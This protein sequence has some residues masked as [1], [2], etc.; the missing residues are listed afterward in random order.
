MIRYPSTATIAKIYD[1]IGPWQDTQAFYEDPALEVLL[2]HGEFDRA[3]SIYE[4]GSGTGRVAR[5]ILR[6]VAERGCRY[7]GAD[8]SPRMV[9]LAQAR[10]APWPNAS[11]VRADITAFSPGAD[12]DRVLSLFVVDLLPDIAIAEFLKRAHE[13]LADD[14]LLCIAGLAEG[15][16]GVSRM[17]SG[18]WK[19]VH[20]RAPAAVGGCRPGQIT[21][22]LDADRWRVLHRESTCAYG[23][24]S[25][26][27]VASKR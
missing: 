12:F 2:K 20:E 18:I 9:A 10:T 19:F 5:R 14:G 25:E 4:A 8:I 17:L 3:G 24:C 6:S 16:S 7:V 15:R 27:V 22:H 26:A 21:P 11:I 23:L 1:R 13:T